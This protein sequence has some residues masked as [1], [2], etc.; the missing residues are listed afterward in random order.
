MVFVGMGVG[1]VDC[2]DER[3]NDDNTMNLILEK[4]VENKGR[5]WI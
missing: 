3:I 2:C 5:K 1:Y 4:I